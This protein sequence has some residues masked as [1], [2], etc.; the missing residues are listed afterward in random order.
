MI[1]LKI[2]GFINALY[3]LSLHGSMNP[4]CGFG[5]GCSFVL[6]SIYASIGGVPLAAIGVATYAVLILAYL[7]MKKEVIDRQ[8][9]GQLNFLVLVPAS[10]V[11][12]ILLLVQFFHIGSFCPFCGLNSLI[13]IALFGLTLREYKWA[14]F[15]IKL[16]GPIIVSLTLVALLP[17]LTAYAYFYDASDNKIGAII[18]GEKVSMNKIEQNVKNDIRNLKRE[19]YTIQKSEV[20]RMMVEMAAKSDNLSVMDY[21]NKTAFKDINIS[22][23]EIESFYNENKDR[24]G[25]TPY[26]V[27]SKRIRQFLRQEKEKKA[28]LNHIPKLV[29]LYE[30][31]YLIDLPNYVQLKPNSI[32][33]YSKGNEQ[34]KVKITE[35]ADIECG[36]CKKAYIEMKS[37]LKKYPDDIYFEYRHYPLPFNKY[38]RSFARASLCAGEQE[39]FWEYLELSFSNQ[40]NLANVSP[41]DFAK[42]LSLDTELFNQCLSASRVDEQLKEDIEAANSVDVQSTPTFIINGQ[43]KIGVLTDS[44][45]RAFL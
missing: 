40:E 14:G 30:A 34:A 7:F 44:D 24:I 12:I 42:K 28:Y 2:I 3:L 22:D 6:T 10:A 8:L 13:L 38:S 9:Y 19:I 27:V 1:I 23:E 39:K 17:I 37:L 43:I 16:N 11:A 45:I 31:E 35:F 15:S 33:V 26:V 4:A 32:K 29:D 41:V 18:A 5:N 36:H 20:D 21:L 25:D